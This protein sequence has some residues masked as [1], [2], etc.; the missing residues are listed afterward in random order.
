MIREWES[1]P[2]HPNPTFRRA[3]HR[4]EAPI[5]TSRKNLHAH[6]AVWRSHGGGD[7]PENLVCTCLFHHGG[8][9]QSYY[10]I[11]CPLLSVSGRAPDDLV[12]EIGLKPLYPPLLRFRGEAYATD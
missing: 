9:H 7:E 11:P 8:I 12:W 5:C 6:H 4:C 1:Q 3:G 10:G 2:D